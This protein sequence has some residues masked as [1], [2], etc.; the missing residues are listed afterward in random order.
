MQSSHGEFFTQ[1]WMSLLE[2]PRNVLVVNHK[3]RTGFEGDRAVFPYV[4]K[5]KHDETHMMPYIEEGEGQKWSR[6][7]YVMYG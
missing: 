5:P 2:G 6:T 4:P 3:L 7:P 1:K